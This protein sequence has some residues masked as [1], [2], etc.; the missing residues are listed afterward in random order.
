MESLISFGCNNNAK[1]Q[2]ICLRKLDELKGLTV[3]EKLVIS[4]QKFDS[5]EIIL[6]EK[7]EI[8]TG[9]Q[10]VFDAWSQ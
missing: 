9:E 4:S 5:R 3:S 2:F 7:Q 6:K 10:I 1:R 8:A